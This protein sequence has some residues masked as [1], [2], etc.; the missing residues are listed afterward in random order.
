MNSSTETYIALKEKLN[1]AKCKA[2]K[3]RRLADDA[4]LL[5]QIREQAYSGA[6]HRVRQLDKDVT[7]MIKKNKW[8]VWKWL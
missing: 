6:C 4:A 3:M 2:E 7:E 5:C 8:S 1:E